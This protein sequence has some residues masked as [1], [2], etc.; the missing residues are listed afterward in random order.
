MTSPRPS[1]S[2]CQKAALRLLQE[3]TANPF[4]TG[5][6]ATG[7]SFL[8]REFLKNRDRK[9][10]PVVAST[11]SAA[12]WVGGRT[13]HSFFGLGIMEGGLDRTVDRALSNRRIVNRL[14]KT[15]GFVLDEVSMISGTTLRAA[16]AIARFAR[17]DERPWGGMR[18]IAVGDFAQLPPVTPSGQRD[19][20]FLDETWLRSDFT[21]VLL[22]TM[23]RSEISNGAESRSKFTQQPH[24]LN[25]A[26]AFCF[27]FTGRANTVHIP[28]E[29]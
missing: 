14:K 16:E 8:I 15:E 4:I 5:A 22:R 7:K 23:L 18:V 2:P 21:L 12:V 17:G 29:V 19:W 28:I 1:W 11:G 27:Q 6:A 26:L 10:F 24:Q 25:I 13:F 9:K 3:D 20:A